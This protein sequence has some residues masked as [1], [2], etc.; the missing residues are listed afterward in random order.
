MPYFSEDTNPN[1]FYSCKKNSLY[2]I[3]ICES[4]S[5]I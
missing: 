1:V 4:E 5:R 3:V 2:N